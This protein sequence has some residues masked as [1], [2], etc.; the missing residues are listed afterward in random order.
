M[1][2]DGG[3][4]WTEEDI[5]AAA[6]KEEEA[7]SWPPLPFNHHHHQYIMNNNNNYQTSSSFSA[8]AINVDD[9]YITNHDDD[10]ISFPTTN[11]PP[12]ECNLQTF[13]N[14]TIDSSSSC[15]PS[16][17]N[18]N[19]FSP[20]PNPNNIQ[21]ILNGFDFL[22]PHL[23]P[24]SS[25]LTTSNPQFPSSN[26]IHL[27]PENNVMSY[28]TP[29]LGGFDDSLTTFLNR[30]KLLK[31][32]DNFDSN[33]AQPTLFQ[34]R[35]LRKNSMTS[36][37]GKKIAE[38]REEPNEKKR[39]VKKSHKATEVVEDDDDDDDVSLV[40][41]GLKNYDS[42]TGPLPLESSKNGGNNN[43]NSSNGNSTVSSG[44]DLKGKKKKGGGVPA[45]N[46]MAERRRRKKLNDRLYML[47]SVVPKIS[48]MDRASI[49]GDAIEYLKELLQKINS[50]H[51]E[52]ESSPGPSSSSS[53]NNFYPVTP[54]SLSLPNNVKEELCSTSSLPTPNSQATR[55]EVRAAKEG[56]AVNIHMLCGRKPGI[57][58]S[59]MRA[60]D[61]LGLD[62]QQAVVSCFNGFSMDVFRA[63]QPGEEDGQDNSIH[64]EQIKAV[65]MESAGLFSNF[66]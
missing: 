5:V 39:R 49:L 14:P 62:V 34:K 24:V 63:E 52:L 29:G 2:A 32:L 28:P 47:R 41:S 4:V 1:R 30:S 18:T 13:F 46:L 7:T 12:P 3:L 48:K 60:L 16:Q 45:K 61:N 10:I 40:G 54:T 37:L 17:L 23:F 22:D 11:F 56:R 31:P 58:L 51:G 57:L 15:S 6:D 21:S 38:K 65:L 25:D 50:L 43:N 35:A 33:A 27:P 55:V 9:W 53:T 66:S 64:P 26:L 19:Y 44:G 59:T 8:A 20:P 42:D 36:D